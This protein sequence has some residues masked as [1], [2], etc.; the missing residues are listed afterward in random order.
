MLKERESYITH[1][2]SSCWAINGKG[3]Q[4]ACV[5]RTKVN[6]WNSDLGCGV[7]TAASSWSSEMT[8]REKA[9]RKSCCKD[10]EKV[11]WKLTIV[12]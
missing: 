7:L 3:R 6:V 4:S 2:E 9:K 5:D 11:R 8:I 10:E 1:G 12:L